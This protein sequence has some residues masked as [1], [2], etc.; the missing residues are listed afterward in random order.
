MKYA[1][2]RS[3]AFP[4]VVAVRSFEWVGSPGSSPALR[5]AGKRNRTAES[6][7]RLLVRRLVFGVVV[8]VCVGVVLRLVLAQATGPGEPGSLERVRTRGTIPVLDQARA[9]VQSQPRA[10]EPAAAVGR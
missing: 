9:A 1:V 7:M 2:D 5:G 10:L 6:D 3:L 4:T 8:A